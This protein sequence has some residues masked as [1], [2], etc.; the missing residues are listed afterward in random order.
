M[1]DFLIRFID[2]TKCI[3]LKSSILKCISLIRKN[4]IDISFFSKNHQSSPL[5]KNIYYLFEF[6]FRFRITFFCFPLSSLLKEL[7][8]Q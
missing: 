5:G 3:D 7:L 8:E 4:Y 2:I 1:Q 6:E